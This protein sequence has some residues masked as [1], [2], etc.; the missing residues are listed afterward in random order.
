LYDAAGGKA[1]ALNMDGETTGIRSIDNGK[2]KID[3]EADAIYMLDSRRVAKPAK[4]LY[5]VNGKKTV[6]K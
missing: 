6:V 2:L 1:F 4:G 5:M 3:N